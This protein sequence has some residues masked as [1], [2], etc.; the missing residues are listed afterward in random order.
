VRLGSGQQCVQLSQQQQQQQQ[1]L[2]G[3]VSQ[4]LPLLQG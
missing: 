4:L 2:E 3:W 1:Q